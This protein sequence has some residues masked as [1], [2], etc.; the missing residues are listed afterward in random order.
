MSPIIMIMN[1]DVRLIMPLFKSA[2]RVFEKKNVVEYGVQQLNKDLK[3]LC[4]VGVSSIIH[5]LIAMPLLY[6]SNKIGFFFPKWMF[7]QG[8]CF[9]IRKSVF[10]EVG[11]F[12][13]RL[14]MYREEDD[15]H[16]RLMKKDKKNTIVFNNKLSYLHLHGNYM[17]ERSINNCEH[18]R[19]SLNNCIL[20]N[21]E[22][23][24]NSN[25]ILRRNILST[26][27]LILKYKIMSWFKHDEQT[28]HYYLHL[29]QWLLCINEIK[30]ATI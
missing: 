3:K 21:K 12:D 9:F 26:Q 15:I 24:I 11:L 27:M 28:L 25:I 8:A 19:A 4:S 30:K 16:Y 20:I 5:P 2:L 7:L 10:E 14:F 13:E 6:L 18:E 1:P 17:T 22:R 23:G 29:K